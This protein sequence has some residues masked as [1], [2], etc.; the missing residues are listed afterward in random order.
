MGIFTE[1]TEVMPE[2]A[3]KILR[4]LAAAISYPAGGSVFPVAYWSLLYAAI[5]N[6]SRRAILGFTLAGVVL[7]LTVVVSPWAFRQWL[8]RRRK[9]A[10]ECLGTL[11]AITEAYYASTPAQDQA[12]TAVANSVRK[13]VGLLAIRP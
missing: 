2:A 5:D 9:A 6:L 7:T 13:L 1:W 3:D 10:A 4:A 11:E 12:R 8:E